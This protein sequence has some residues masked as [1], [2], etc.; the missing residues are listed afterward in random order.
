[1]FGVEPAIERRPCDPGPTR[2]GRKVSK[3]FRFTVLLSW[4]KRSLPLWLGLA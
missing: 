1:M 3:L 4:P 2:F